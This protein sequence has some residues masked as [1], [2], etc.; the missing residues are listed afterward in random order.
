MLAK[1]AAL[2]LTFAMSTSFAA[3]QVV[4]L[5][6]VADATVDQSQPNLNFGSDQQL[7]FGK[8]FTYTP[9]FTVWFLR[10]HL[11]FD[12]SPL[13]GGPVPQRARLFWYQATASAA[14]CLPVDLFAVTAPWG[15]NTV[16]WNTKPSHA[17]LP[18]ASACVGDSFAP[19][20]K[21]FDV[22]T[23]VQGW[24]DGSVPNFGVVIRDPSESQAGAARPGFGHSRESTSVA[25]RPY[26][27]IDL[28][29]SFG[30]GC[31][32]GGSVLGHA[33]ALG[34][35]AIGSTFSLATTGFQPNS[36]VVSIL[37]LDNTAWGAI[38]LPASLASLGYAGCSL[39]VA[40][41][42]LLASGPIASGGFLLTWPVPNNAALS[43]LTVYSQALALVPGASF[44]MSG[45]LGVTLY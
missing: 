34:T 21:Q 37:G 16:T 17:A 6:P 42:V 22:T 23:L 4:V 13:A 36:L 20:W 29:S 43:G 26:L 10:G 31:A 8:D 39:H 32:V 15:E 9:T 41:D 18:S 44:Q 40:A 33:F 2:T 45:G 3:S 30:S 12:T 38:P 25:L 19:G 14:G 35:P 7:N 11:L 28:G 27:E 1:I 24:I 5:Q